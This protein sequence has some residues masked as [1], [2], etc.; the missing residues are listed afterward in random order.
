MPVADELKIILRAETAKA[1]REMRRAQQQTNQTEKGFSKLITTVGKSVAGWA[2]AGVSIRAV[3]RTL[4]ESVELAG[5]QEE[6]E[7]KLEAAIIA[8]GKES[9][10]SAEA[11]K[12]LASS[13]QGVTTFGDEATIAAAGLVQSLANLNQDQLATLLPRIQDF[14]SAMGMDLHQAASLVGKSIGSST[15]ALTRYGVE[16]DNSLTGTERFAAIMQGLDEKFGG[17][18]EAVADTAS[19]AMIQLQNSIGDTKERLGAFLI[20]SLEPAVRELTKFFD[21]INSNT[22]DQDALDAML[23]G[24]NT[25]ADIQRIN[26]Q[27]EKQRAILEEQGGENTQSA[28]GLEAKFAIQNLELELARLNAARQ[29]QQVAEYLADQEGRGLEARKENLAYLERIQAVEDEYQSTV[30]QTNILRN[31][32][33]LDAETATRRLEQAA[34]RAATQLAGMEFTPNLTGSTKSAAAATMRAYIDQALS[35]AE[36]GGS[37]VGEKFWQSV[38]DEG[39]SALMNMYRQNAQYMAPLVRE[40][41]EEMAN[42]WS[43][44]F[45]TI[46]GSAMQTWQAIIAAQN[47]A[48]QNRISNIDKELD[49]LSARHE[50]QIAWLEATGASEEEIAQRRAEQLEEEAQAEAA[51]EKRKKKLAVQQFKRQKAFNTANVIQQTALAAMRA[52]A[53]LGPIAGPVAAAAISAMGA[54]QLQ[55]IQSQE[56]PAFEKGGSF[57]TSGPQMIMVGD[58]QSPRERVTVEPLTGPYAR[59]GGQRPIVVNVNGI[60]SEDIAIKIKRAI[61]RAE[62]RGAA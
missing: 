44:A 9:Q 8:T 26:E 16:I 33:L 31:E 27:L 54:K 32:G 15:N 38:N 12:E 2:A 41:P 22:S 14:A 10:V 18:S 42:N 62:D 58:G 1:V 13:L 6:A 11:I 52:W 47:R 24:D 56:P 61:S 4:K 57:V 19:G 50:R 7:R 37:E 49:A 60:I 35:F 46:L 40:A 21:T 43:G 17:F 59:G 20:E 39:A 53:D 36:E 55:L 29:R 48:T 30:A 23:G 3:V 51:A 25:V 28:M 5:I 45:T 34:R